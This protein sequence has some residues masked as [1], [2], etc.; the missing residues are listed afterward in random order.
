MCGSVVRGMPVVTLQVA[1]S[2]PSERTEDLLEKSEHKATTAGD[3][4]S[5]LW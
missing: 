1:A 5:T 3:I 2:L 4:F